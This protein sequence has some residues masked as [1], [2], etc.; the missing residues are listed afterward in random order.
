MIAEILTFLGDPAN[1]IGHLFE[2]LELTFV[3]LGLAL[4]IAFPV[5]LFVG[6]TGRGGTVLVGFSNAMRALPTLG[7]VTFMFMIFYVNF[8]GETITYPAAVIGLV[9]LAIPAILAGTYAGVQAC[10]PSVADASLGV[11]MTRWQR[12]WQVKVPIALPVMLGGVRNA[13][14]QLVST[15]TVAA[16]IS[17]GGLGR[18]LLDGLANRDYYQVVVGAVLTALLAIALDLVLAGLQRLI[19]SPGV[20]LATTSR[21]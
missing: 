11:G 17:A 18:I 5:G 12:L 20:A 8:P 14:L 9:V 21:T 6:E 1:W 15:V 13:V 10:D 4:I 7:L 16:Y 19:V 3:S 2:H